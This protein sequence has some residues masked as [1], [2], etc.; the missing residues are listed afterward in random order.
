MVKVHPGETFLAARDSATDLLSRAPAANIH[1]VPPDS[2][3]TAH[4][5]IDVA[6]VALVYTSTIAAEAASLGTPVILVGGGR[7]A[8]RG[9]TIDVATPAEYFDRLQR[10][11][12]SHDPLRVPREPARRY[13]HAFFIRAALPMRWF[14]VSDINVSEILLDSINDLVPG[15]DP[16][17]DAICRT[18][19]LDELPG[20]SPVSSPVLATA[21]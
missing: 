1:V 14:T 4:S 8:G 2:P 15:R 16:A 20:L 7:H 5:V 10:C 18:V 11:L 9:F 12:T 6:D 3:L 17:M 13:A 21:P 19:L